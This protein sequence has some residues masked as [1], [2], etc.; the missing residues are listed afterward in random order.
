L[1]PNTQFIYLSRK[2]VEAVDLP[3]EEIIECVE[4]SLV[5]KAHKRTQMPPKHWMELSTRWFGAMSS[6]VPSVGSAAVKWQSGS[7]R[8]AAVGLPYITGLLILNDI[9]SGLPVSIMDS[10]WITAK[11]TAAAT[12][13]AAKHLAA[14]KPS[15]FS[16]IGCGVQG[17]TNAEAL[18]I[19]CP[20]LDE[21]HCY[22]IDPGAM[23]NYAKEM[24]Q[25][26]G[27][28]VKPCKGPR[29]AIESGDIVVTGAPITAACTR[30]V[31]KGWLKKGA[32]GVTLD[33][34]C[35]WKSESFADL[36][37]LFTDDVGQMNHLR[38]YGYFLGLPK[39]AGEIGEVAAGLLPGRRS[40]DD[41]IV[42]INMGVSV[43]DV[44]TARRVFERAR[45]RKIGIS[46][47]L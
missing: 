44:T 42:S 21:I 1:K 31:G 22:D 5:E 7:P 46:L 17:R 29:E 16:L 14:R 2:D 34:D 6:I 45:E 25:L 11:R 37:L 19:V 20:S 30:V 38:E 28:K 41:R 4:T 26:H 15:I 47:S 40:E 35:Y 3:M 43:E 12:A 36:D 24:R 27:Y 9:D 32:L 8:N 18:H 13:V 33:Y 10:T 39:V 23:E